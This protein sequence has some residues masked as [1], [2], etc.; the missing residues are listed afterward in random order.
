[1]L[2][3]P[4]KRPG[5]VGFITACVLLAAALLAIPAQAAPSDLDPA[6][7]GSGLVLTPFSS[8]NVTDPS[9]SIAS[10]VAAQPDGALVAA[11][12]FSDQF[13]NG[14]GFAVARYG[15]DGG[16]DSGFGTGGQ[17]VTDFP[18]FNYVR[19]TA[20]IVQPDG[21]L[22]VGGSALSYA[23]GEVFALARYGSDGSL[24]S[25]FGSSGRVTTFFG[26]YSYGGLKAMALQDDGKLVATGTF[27]SPSGGN[28]IGV[29]RYNADG[30]LD[31]TFGSSGLTLVTTFYYW[32]APDARAVVVQP[33]GKILVASPAAGQFTLIRLNPDGSL[34]GSFGSG[35]IA[36]PRYGYPF[37]LALQSD[38]KIIEAGMDGSGFRLVVARV[39]SDGT[40]DTSFGVNGSAETDFLR[41]VPVAVY[42]AA[43]A[44]R[45]QANG[46]IVAAGPA[47]GNQQYFALARFNGD[48]TL[49]S[50]FGNGGRILTTFPATTGQVANALSLQADG[51]IVAA[52]YANLPNGNLVFALARYLGDPTDTVPPVL[53]LPS[54]VRIDAASSDGARVDYSSLV[55]ATD[56]L[57]PNPTVSCSPSSGSPFAMG[58]TVVSCTATDAAE[59]S[60]SGSF[61]VHVRDAAK[62]VAD[63]LA[64]VDSYQLG[65]LGTSLHDKLVTVLRFLD[66]EKPRQA[67]DNLA[68]FIAQ[69]DAQRG[70][71]LTQEQADA[72]ETAA[73]RIIDV[74]E[75]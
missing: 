66:S 27:Q 54:V 29:A 4:S 16:L 52:G 40:P 62:Q 42:T 19:G 25:S 70:K 1:M 10:A 2:A 13:G 3:S 51:R 71:G 50:G 74:I 48:G 14:G 6:F 39:N 67:E 73:Q 55:S 15:S 58:D 23:T 21:R 20:L 31:A 41:F 26:T 47:S 33:D 65:K 30:S 56:N 49:D 8:S 60:S 57:D 61:T 59:N 68:A 64:L 9:R 75:T 32:E 7:G 28:A 69:V 45:V 12:T 22:V 36:R 17:V 72:L 34:D 37:A 46:K 38:G 5:R 11:G 53:Q 63:L 44:V 35:G 43:L 24:D 18:G